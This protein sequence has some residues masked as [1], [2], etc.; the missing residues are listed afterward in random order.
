MTIH[1]MDEV[2]KYLRAL[3]VLQVH[4]RNGD[5]SPSKPELLLAN[6][7]LSHREIADLLGKKVAA[8]SKAIERARKTAREEEKDPALPPGAGASTRAAAVQER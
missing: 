6:A 5:E 3:V 4:A 2:I 8:V 1:E 7:G